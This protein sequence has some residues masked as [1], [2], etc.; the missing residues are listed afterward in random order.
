[1]GG[2][3]ISNA[4]KDMSSTTPEIVEAK[5]STFSTVG[6]QEEMLRLISSSMF[7]AL[8]AEQRV[9]ED[10]AQLLAELDR[11]QRL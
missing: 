3:V 7:M 9:R 6:N 4:L 5:S 10:A 2:M 1:M 11:Q 8:R